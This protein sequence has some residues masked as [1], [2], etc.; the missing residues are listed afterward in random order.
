MHHILPRLFQQLPNRSLCLQFA[1]F[2]FVCLFVCFKIYLFERGGREGQRERKNLKQTPHW[3]WSRM[4]GSEIMTTAKIKS[5]MLNR[6]SHPGVLVLFLVHLSCHSKNYSAYL[7]ALFPWNALLHHFYL[8]NFSHSL[9]FSWSIIISL[10][11]D[12]QQM[13]RA[14]LTLTSC[15]N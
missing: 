1:P 15:L 4:Q 14:Q 2:L 13:I 6:L 11:L 10:M 9:T 3:A 5:W 12:D 7:C 8:A